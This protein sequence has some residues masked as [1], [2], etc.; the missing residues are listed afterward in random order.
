MKT[1]RGLLLSGAAA[2][3]P[4]PMG[5]QPTALACPCWAHHGLCTTSCLPREFVA[6]GKASE[7]WPA[8]HQ[9]FSRLC[10]PVRSEVRPRS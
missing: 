1:T 10:L 2:T 9:W 6:A 4:A 5:I 8:A 3:V 7:A